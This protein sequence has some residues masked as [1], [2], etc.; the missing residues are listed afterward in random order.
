M[1]CRAACFINIEE[2]VFVERPWSR[3]ALRAARSVEGV[4]IRAGQLLG[5]FNLPRRVADDISVVFVSILS[6]VL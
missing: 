4:Q 5:L 6:H 3:S 2:I 1:Q